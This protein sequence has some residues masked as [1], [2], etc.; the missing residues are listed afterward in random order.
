MTTYKTRSVSFARRPLSFAI[1]LKWRLPLSALGLWGLLAAHP[2]VL[3]KSPAPAT[4]VHERSYEALE[5]HARSLADEIGMPA[6]RRDLALSRL[7]T[8]FENGKIAAFSKDATLNGIFAYQMGEGGFLVKVKKGKGAA[9]LSS[10]EPKVA[11]DFKSV[12]FGAQVG[13]GSEWGFGVILGLR[14]TAAFGG[15]YEGNT[16]GATAGSESLNITKLTKNGLSTTD[17]SYHELYLVAVAKGLSA[18]AAIGN[19]T[20]LRR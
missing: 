7:R 4:V 3:A 13:G 1:R 10:T 6:D 20:I 14:N 19:L 16:R 11:L 2:E 15:D 9:Y 17:P 12:T 8:A 18:G 5:K